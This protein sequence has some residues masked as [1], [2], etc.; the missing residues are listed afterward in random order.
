[1]EAIGQE[2][3]AWADGVSKEHKPLL[4]PARDFEFGRAAAGSGRS[5]WRGEPLA[6]DDRQ[7][8]YGE[9]A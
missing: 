7:W 8:G 2:A 9:M 4:W 6:L 1:M 5:P 3:T